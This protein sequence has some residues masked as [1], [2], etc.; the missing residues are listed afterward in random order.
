MRLSIVGWASGGVLA[1]VLLA[2]LS[3]GLS[4]PADQA[5]RSLV[6][7]PAPELSVSTLD[8]A[9]VRISDLKGRPL[10]LNFWASWCPPCR[11][12]DPALKAAAQRLAG[13][14]QFVGVDIQ[15]QSAAARAYAADQRQPYPVGPPAS[16]SYVD[17]GVT[18]PPETFFIDGKGIVVAKFIGPLDP[19]TLDVYLRMLG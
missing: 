5:P 7:R 15:D 6:G 9:T 19:A 4:H 17:Y 10:V 8:G 3:W 18:A 1:A 13:Q 12:E 14:V 16:G 2:A 11:E